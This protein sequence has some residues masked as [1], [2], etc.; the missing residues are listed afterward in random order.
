[1]SV[2]EKL[3]ERRKHNRFSVSKGAFVALRPHYGKIGQVVNISMGGLAFTYMA[4]EERPSSFELDIFLAGGSFYLQEVPFGTISDFHND[5]MPLSSVKMRRM[6]VQFGDL[7]PHQ[8]SQLEY[9]IQNHTE[10]EEI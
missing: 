9:F 10:G 4:D 7:S 2:A 8:V 1:M 3:V 5:G 6:G